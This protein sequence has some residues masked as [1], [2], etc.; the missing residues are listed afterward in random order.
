MQLPHSSQRRRGSWTLTFL[1]RPHLAAAVGKVAAFV[2]QLAQDHV[3]LEEKLVSH[4][5]SAGRERERETQ[6]ERD[7]NMEVG[8][9]PRFSLAPE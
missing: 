1:L 3:V 4:A 2:V 5:K 8:L 9:R 6:R 7:K